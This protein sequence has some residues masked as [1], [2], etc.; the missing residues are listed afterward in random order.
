[1][2]I[3]D[4]IEAN[5]EQLKIRNSQAVGVLE[6]L[7]SNLEKGPITL[8]VESNKEQKIHEFSKNRK[9][10]RFVYQPHTFTVMGSLCSN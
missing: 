6:I 7:S 10:M 4:N 2:N 1:M 3:L 8:K 9:K 5:P